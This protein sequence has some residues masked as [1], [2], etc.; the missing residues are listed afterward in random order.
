MLQDFENVLNDRVG[1]AH[2]PK[3]FVCSLLTMA[4]V[5]PVQNMFGYRP[6]GV[7][8]E[9]CNEDALVWQCMN[10][11]GSLCG[12]CVF[13]HREVPGL[14]LADINADRVDANEVAEG[15][16]TLWNRFFERLTSTQA[17]GHS[18]ASVFGSAVICAGKMI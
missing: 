12:R 4:F 17:A 8:C 5:G 1:S 18:E 15:M 9:V 3:Y 13:Q 16:F 14:A 11:G 10:C 7:F 6:V 2:Q